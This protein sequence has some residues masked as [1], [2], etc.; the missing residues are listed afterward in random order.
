VHD[1]PL[2]NFFCFG[3]G[4]DASIFTIDE[5]LPDVFV[6]LAST[7]RPDASEDDL[8]GPARKRHRPDNDI[9]RTGAK[10]VPGG[11]QDKV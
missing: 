5:P 11:E 3:A 9:H 1:E 8:D 7:R 4:G 10:C 2:S 6:G